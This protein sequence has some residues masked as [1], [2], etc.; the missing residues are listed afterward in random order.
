M[1]LITFPEQ[2]VEIAKHQPQYRTM[3]AYMRSSDPDGEVIC[4][5]KLTLWERL[6]VLITGRLWHRML[7]FHA[8]LQPQLL[9][10]DRP[11]FL[12]AEQDGVHGGMVEGNEGSIAAASSKTAGPV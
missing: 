2:T 9:Q 12:P 10:V 6:M 5:W 3:P 11:I 1:R 8:K 7:T 4:C